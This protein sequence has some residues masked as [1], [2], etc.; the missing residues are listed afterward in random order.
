MDQPA[1]PGGQDAYPTR[2]STDSIPFPK[3]SKR[4]DQAKLP[5]RLNQNCLNAI[6]PKV[7][8]FFI[9]TNLLLLSPAPC[10][11]TPHNSNPT[12]PVKIL[13]FLLAIE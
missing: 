11:P 10:S 12:S 2:R 8:S 4:L 7:R 9:S 3:P 5:Q 13:D 1:E 6:V